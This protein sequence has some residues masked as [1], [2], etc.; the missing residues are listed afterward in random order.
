M[1]QLNCKYKYDG[2]QGSRTTIKF[3]SKLKDYGSIYCYNT[4]TGLNLMQSNTA[5]LP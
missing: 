4:L 2:T 5:A 3:F 1:F